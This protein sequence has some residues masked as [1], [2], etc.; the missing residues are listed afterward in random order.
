M[1]KT[2]LILFSLAAA[3]FGSGCF[4]VNPYITVTESQLNWVEIHYYN[5]KSKPVRRYWVRLSGVGLVE[6]KKGTSD[7]VSNDFAKNHGAETWRDIKTQRK[8]VDP[9]HLNDIFQDLVNYGLLDEEKNFR[10][11]NKDGY[12]RFIAVKANINNYTYS[13]SVNIFEEDPDLA[14]KLLDV[15]WEFSNPTL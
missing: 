7:L 8:Q 9:K 6:T 13:E 4:L 5:T 2:L 11:A 3:T 14:E 15:V 1:R 12:D 10:G